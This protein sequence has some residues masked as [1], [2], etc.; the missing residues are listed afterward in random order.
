VIYSA[1]HRSIDV[2]DLLVDYPGCIVNPK[3]N[4]GDTPL[5]LA[6]RLDDEELD[7]LDDEDAVRLDIVDELLEKIMEDRVNLGYGHLC[8]NSYP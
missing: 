6:V 4:D 1:R 8:Q 2:L 7:E 3:N 5:H